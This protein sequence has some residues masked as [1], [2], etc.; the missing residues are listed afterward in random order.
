MQGKLAGC[1]PDLEV[2]RFILTAETVRQGLQAGDSVP[3]AAGQ[4]SP[5]GEETEGGDESEED[6]GAGIA[7]AGKAMAGADDD[8]AK[9]ILLNR[10]CWFVFLP[11]N[12]P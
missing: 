6:I 11:E 10:R 2:I 5:A 4:Q 8:F 12:D 1:I 7:V 3:P 9:D